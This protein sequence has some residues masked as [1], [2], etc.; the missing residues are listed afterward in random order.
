MGIAI[1]LLRVPAPVYKRSG[2]ALE[3]DA[4]A[5]SRLGSVVLVDRGPH[6]MHLCPR[7]CLQAVAVS[8]ELGE[9]QGLG[10]VECG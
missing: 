7:E 10:G 1:T 9:I 4:D 6:T 2:T 3:H 8:R 5:G